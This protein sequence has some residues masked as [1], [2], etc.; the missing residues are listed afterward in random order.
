MFDIDPKFTNIP[1][2]LIMNNGL[3]CTGGW[4]EATICNR[5]VR[6]YS[7]RKTL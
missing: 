6:R 2:S 7:R 1:C 3:W 5:Y 4:R